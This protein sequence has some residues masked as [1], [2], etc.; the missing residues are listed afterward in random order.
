MKIWRHSKTRVRL[1]ETSFLRS[2]IRVRPLRAAHSR[3]RRWKVS[4][5][6]EGSRN[7][8]ARTKDISAAPLIRRRLPPRAG[9]AARDIHNKNTQK[10]LAATP[11]AVQEEE[12]QHA[13]PN[14]A[15]EESDNWSGFESTG[16]QQA[17]QGWRDDDRA[18][19]DSSEAYSDEVREQGGGDAAAHA[20]EILERLGRQS[21]AAE[22]ANPVRY[23]ENQLAQELESRL[24]SNPPGRPVSVEETP[25]DDDYE[26]AEDTTFDDRL[27]REIEKTQEHAGEPVPSRQRGGLALAA[28]WGLFL[29]AASGLVIGFLTFRDI[30]ADALPGLTPVYRKIGL[31]VTVQPLIFESVQYKWAISEDKP[32]IVISGSV[33]NRSQRKV[34]VPE[35]FITIK[36]QNPELDNEYSANLPGGSKIKGGQRTDFEIELYSPNRTVTAIE[37]ELR[38]V[39]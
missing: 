27:Y 29:C 14:T 12:Y 10:I 36:D 32:L 7:L 18:D 1:C 5:K 37:L 25:Q 8:R 4:V 15:R 22:N 11:K 33:Y 21:F 26:P 17:S 34:K 2:R 3:R 23:G 24:R 6:S 19:G 35:F 20:R 16:G 28:G 38:N 13:E 30:V 9:K 31:P 39:H